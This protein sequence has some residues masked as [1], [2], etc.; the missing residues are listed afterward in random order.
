MYRFKKV[1][2]IKGIF[3]ILSLC[4]LLGCNNPSRGNREQTEELP[5]PVSALPASTET[6]VISD[7]PV[8]VRVAGVAAGGLAQA[9]SEVFL[10]NVN[11]EKT[12]VAY[13]DSGGNFSFEIS[14]SEDFPLIL[15]VNRSSQTPLCTI[16]TKNAAG[17]DSLISH[18]NP[19]TTLVCHSL[20]GSNL[21]S[22]L[23]ERRLSRLT[24]GQKKL[25]RF[26]T[27]FNQ[28]S[29]LLS[30]LTALDLQTTGQQVTGKI[31]GSGLSFASFSNDPAFQARSPSS[32]VLPS[33]SDSFF[34]TLQSIAQGNNQTLDQLLQ[35]ELTA[36]QSVPFLDQ[37]EFQVGL[38]SVLIG[39][40]YDTVTSVANLGAMVQRGDVVNTIGVIAGKLET[41][42]E[43]AIAQGISNQ[44]EIALL[45]NGVT[46]GIRE[47]IKQE[48]ANQNIQ[49][50]SSLGTDALDNLTT[51]VISSIKGSLIELVKTRPPALSDNFSLNSVIENAAKQV[52]Q[53]TDQ[54]SVISVLD[55]QALGNLQQA[56]QNTIQSTAAVL[57]EAVVNA[58]GDWQSAIKATQDQIAGIAQ[59]NA[60]S[61][62]NLISPP[63]NPVPPISSPSIPAS[64]GTGN[65]SVQGNSILP[66]QNSTFSS[67]TPNLPTSNAGSSASSSNVSGNS[68]NPGNPNN[69]LSPGLPSTTITNGPPTTSP[70]IDTSTAPPTTVP[71]IGVQIL[72]PSTLITVGSSPVKVSGMVDDENLA[73]TVNGSPVALN[74]RSFSTAVTLEEGGNT[75]IARVTNVNTEATASILVYL[76]RTA[77]YI[78]ID[79]LKD[80]QVV[81]TPTVM[82][83]GLVNDI[84]RGTVN[85]EQANVVITSE[86]LN[87][88]TARLSR[89]LARNVVAPVSNRSYLAPFVPL[90]IGENRITVTAADQVGNVNSKSI[91]V[92][93]EAPAENH[94]KLIAGQNQKG[95]IN[96]EVPEALQVKLVNKEGQ[97]LAGNNVVFRVVQ[98]D[99]VVGSET[100]NPAQAVIVQ[101]G[102]DGVAG[103]RFRIGSRSGN[104]N[105]HVKA[106]AVGV[107]GGVLFFASAVPRLPDK[108]T[109]NSGNNQRGGPKQQLGEPF[110]VNITD[111]GANVL[112]DV[113]VEFRVS[114]GKGKLQNGQSVYQTKTDSDGRASAHLTL[115]EKVGMDQHWVTATISKTPLSAVFTASALKTGQPGNTRVSGIVLD[116]EDHPLPNVAVRVEDTTRQAF[117]NAEGQFVIPEVPV[118]PIHLIADGSTTTVPGDWPALSYNMVTVVGADNPLPSPI[119]MLRLNTENAKWV[120]EQDEEFTLPEV[121]G[122]KLKILK[123]SVTFPDGKKSGYLSVTVV[124]S[125][126]VPMAPPN[127]MQPQFIITI[128]P[129]GTMFDPPAPLTLPNFDGHPPG[130]QPE[131][132]SYDHD[133][134][135]FVI[136]GIGKVSEDGQVI[137]SLPGVGVIK[138]GWH[139]G[140]QPTV[141][142]CAHGCNDCQKINPATCA[143]EADP[144]KN[145][146]SIGNFYVCSNGKK[147]R[148]TEA[149]PSGLLKAGLASAGISLRTGKAV[150]NAHWSQRDNSELIEYQQNFRTLQSSLQSYSKELVR[151]QTLRRAQAQETGS[152]YRQLAQKR[153]REAEK[154]FQLARI[155]VL[156]AADQLEQRNTT[157]RRGRDDSQA[158]ANLKRLKIHLNK[159]KVV[160]SPLNDV[161]LQQLRTRSRKLVRDTQRMVNE[162]TNLQQ[163]QIQKL[164]ERLTPKPIIDDYSIIV[165]PEPPQSR[166]VMAPPVPDSVRNLSPN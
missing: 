6:P 80:G 121:P 128:Q 151:M 63:A 163:I 7:D 102:N 161:F 147:V 18:V 135:E 139:C 70:P 8:V 44:A 116:S 56:S 64:G 23:S 93:Y 31:F 42:K 119:Y 55:P 131:L 14:D 140:S 21:P 25:Q 114:R 72:Q 125:S 52:A 27:A 43:E 143:C 160:D 84:V 117:T 166:E 51:N 120:G 112:K 34:D 124:N 45:L 26:N 71:P 62:G 81:S 20:L 29:R 74:G 146:L 95:T 106:T 150:L 113:W 107:K 94:L 149:K 89:S 105:Q 98:G 79:S 134:E 13:T 126:K 133:L 53:L 115:G 99:G 108:I 83:S 50:L 144:E 82:L 158:V 100:A 48:K 60:Q 38:S 101:T 5:S 32:S 67:S 39:V 85:D 66:S 118:G 68:G 154:A 130:A 123:D 165:K 24:G 104:G 164:I 156:K 33:V 152:H 65:L 46:T 162:P 49:K 10:V 28:Q 22:S 37:A 103:T 155:E 122:F 58:K 87:P 111:S 141:A 73:L 41:V 91:T 2:T 109:I 9:N 11:D 132:Y 153:V 129:T 40:G 57:T 110:V 3:L 157:S 19:V 92:R 36:S 47:V 16:L 35:S 142:G 138:A 90:D 75:I 88:G 12:V 148:I 127:G 96:S 159:G 61:F 69:V 97:P 4:L 76:D 145:S 15:A 1:K 17:I 136:I 77:P 137:E 30:D 54:L 78:T 59:G 86:L